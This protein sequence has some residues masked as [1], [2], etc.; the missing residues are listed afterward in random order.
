MVLISAHEQ[1]SLVAG[2][3]C[4]QHC[5]FNI[6]FVHHPYHAAVMPYIHGGIG[7]AQL[8]AFMFVTMSVG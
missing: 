8:C 4:D 3:Y 6:L 2:V 5:M 1:M 7:V